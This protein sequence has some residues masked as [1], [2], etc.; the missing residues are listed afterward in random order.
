[1]KIIYDPVKFSLSAVDTAGAEFRLNPA[2]SWQRPVKKPA[3][4]YRLEI[5]N[6][7]DLK[8]RYCVV[9]M[10]RV[11]KGGKLMSRETARAIVS[12]YN[13]ETGGKGTL[14]MIG[15]EPLLNWEVVKDIA[16][17][18]SGQKM[19][20]TNSLK[21]TPE[22]S[23]YLRDHKVLI[24]TS[25][26]GFTPEHNR[27]RF[28]DDKEGNFETIKVNIRRMVCEG[29]RVGV[30]CVLHHSNAAEAVDIASFFRE[31]LG[32]VSMSFAY[33]HF[34]RENSP[35]NDFRI[36]QYSEAVKGLF[37]FSKRRKVYLDQTGRALRF[38]FGGEPVYDGCKICT[39]Q[40]TF[41]PDGTPTLCTKLDTIPGYSLAGFLDR[42]PLVN[43]ECE[44]CIARGAC[45]GGCPWDAWVAPNAKGFDRRIC[46]YNPAIIN[47][48]LED[49]EQEAA[50]AG[51]IN[52]LK[53]R[54]DRIYKPLM[55]PQWTQG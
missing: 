8:C 22:K 34:T 37:A 25:L 48:L 39:S 36:E 5:A 45:G 17:T 12:Q 11:V 41:Y 44:S 27:A 54:L 9:H 40:R 4:R 43:P 18:A 50:Q 53:T 16:A 42:L 20:F 7:C 6:A 46:S 2:P 55:T 33:P 23:A 28:G 47:H 14:I 30:A 3:D 13:V 19:I 29:C 15:G 10:N 49:I 51:D 1:M 21:M 31:E 32:V 24:L 35:E 26:D 38:L 52:A